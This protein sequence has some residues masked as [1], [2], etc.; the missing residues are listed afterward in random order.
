MSEAPRNLAGFLLERSRLSSQDA[1][2]LHRVDG[3]W[4]TISYGQ[5]ESRA[6]DV[7]RGLFSMGV[8]AGTPVMVMARTTEQW[9]LVAWASAILG[10]VL[11]PVHYTLSEADF[12]DMAG[13]VRPGFL[14]LGDP[15]LLVRMRNS[16]KS[17]SCPIGIMETRCVL[18]DA[19]SGARPYLRMEDVVSN[20]EEAVSLAQIESLGAD[21]R[22]KSRVEELGLSRPGDAPALVIF[23]AGTLGE[24]KGAVLTHDNVLYQARTLSFLLP[25]GRDDVQLVF[26]PFSHI[27]GIIAFLTSV[28][29]GAPMALGG[30]M[31][32]LLEDL[33]DVRPTFMVGVPRVYEKIVE[34]LKAGTSDYS[35]VWWE[36]YRRGI[37]AGQDVIEGRP[38]GR[39]FDMAAKLQLDLAR[40]TV[41][42]RCREIFGGRMRFL[43]SGGAPLPVEVAHTV[44]AFGIPLLDGFGLTEASGATHLNR[45]EGPRV[46]TVGAPLPM[47]Q[48][49]I[50]EDGEVLLRGPGIM[51]G[52]LNDRDATMAAVDQDGWLHTGDLG[53]LDPDGYLKITG[54]KKNIIVTSSGKNILPSKIE[55]LLATIP[56]VSHAFVQGDGKPFL[57]ALVTVS[58]S[59]LEEWAARKSIPAEAT[60]K[61]R[62]DIRLYKDIEGEVERVNQQLAP[63]ER[64]RKFAILDADFSTE[65]GELTHDFKVRRRIVADK[66]RDVMQTLYKERF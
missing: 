37:K 2:I 1:A 13:R 14:F 17:I 43:I 38:R 34:K 35:I 45:P 61:L 12:K 58:P 22:Q 32:S 49:R 60:E 59:R 20:R 44:N 8:E 57:V 29:A 36:V 46:G 24:Q 18:G 65:T 52:Y 55:S 5:L 47:V 51:A 4:K 7:A 62:S 30:G 41:F 42:Q 16:V 19:P 25:V 27:L 26:L 31:R 56:L 6:M 64:I 48:T 28:A 40:R 66:Y 21:V 15:G 10:A 39:L 23:T 63:Y 53:A 50:A 11:V 3:G 9:L 33:R 54:R